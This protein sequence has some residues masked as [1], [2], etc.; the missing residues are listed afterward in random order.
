MSINLQPWIKFIKYL[1]DIF[2]PL[3]LL[4]LYSI[5][6]N[7]ET[8][9]TFSRFYYLQGKGRGWKFR[10]LERIQVWQVNKFFVRRYTGATMRLTITERREA[11]L[12][13]NFAIKWD[14]EGGRGQILGDYDFAITITNEHGDGINRQAW[15]GSIPHR[16]E[17]KSDFFDNY[18]TDRCAVG[19]KIII[20]ADSKRPSATVQFT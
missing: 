19:T 3:S 4:I 1:F 2:I 5:F 14:K 6:F 10:G 12:T 9:S 15:C 7:F 11:I 17:M 13:R 20:T 18:C 16:M 8:H